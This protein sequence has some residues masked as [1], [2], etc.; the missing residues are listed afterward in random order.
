M[1]D[2]IQTVAESA[3]EQAID[4]HLSGNA[5]KAAPLF[6]RATIEHRRSAPSEDGST[7][8]PDQWRD[9]QELSPMPDAPAVTSE[10]DAAVTKLTDMG[11]A[12]ADLVSSWGQD[13]AVN[14]EYARSAFREMVASDPG[15]VAAVDRSGIGDHPAVLEHLAKYGRLSA[16]MMGDF[17]TRIIEPM[18][19]NRTGPTGTNR[20]SGGGSAREELDRIMAANPPGSEAYRQPAI[21]RRVEE[22]SKQIVGTGNVIGRGGRTA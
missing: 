12:H 4:A 19:I 7:P 5:E 15:L 3:T 6:N 1:T 18:T 17:S 10:T 11:G 8:D 21:Q 9:G 16:G 20:S 13:A 2:T 14:V 22:L